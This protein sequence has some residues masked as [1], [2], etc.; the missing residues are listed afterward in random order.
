MEYLKRIEKISIYLG[1]F[2]A[3]MFF[4]FFFL[5]FINFFNKDIE[6][7]YIY[8]LFPVLAINIAGYLLKK[9]L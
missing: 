5:F 9:Y 3:L 6:I 1:Y 2:C 8:I 4:S 7:D